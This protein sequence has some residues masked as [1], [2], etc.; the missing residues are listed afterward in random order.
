MIILPL[1]NK[2]PIL[3][4]VVV[5]FREYRT[6]RE[7]LALYVDS[8]SQFGITPSLPLCHPEDLPRR[9]GLDPGSLSV[10]LVL[11]KHEDSG[12]RSG[13]TEERA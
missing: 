3:S 13:M 5:L 7:D 4:I 8:G 11:L 1:Y 6:S 12:S 2:K 9:P 10:A